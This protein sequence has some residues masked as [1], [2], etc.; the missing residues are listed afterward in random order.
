MSNRRHTVLFTMLTAALMGSS[1]MAEEKELKEVGTTRVVVAALKDD[2]VAEEAATSLVQV[3]SQTIERIGASDLASALKYES[4]IDVDMSSSGRLNDVRIRGVGGDRVMVAIDGAP[5]PQSYSFGSYLTVGRGYFDVDA[6]KSIDVIKGP[7]SMLYG[8]SALAGGIFMQTKDPADFIKAGNRYGFEAK[9]GYNT[10][11]RDRLMTLTAAAH[12]TD[13]LSGFVRATFRKHYETE[14]YNGKAFKEHHLG[15]QRVNPDPSEANVKNIL[16]KWVFEPNAEHKIAL[17]YEYFYDNSWTSLLSRK[18]SSIMG[19]TTDL[20][21]HSGTKSTRQQVNIR[22]DFNVPIALFDKGHWMAYYQNTRARQLQFEER[23]SLRKV[24]S[25]RWRKS[26]FDSD[27][28]GLTLE[29]NKGLS[30]GSV[31]H[32]LTYGANY[33]HTKVKTMRTGDTVRRIDGISIETENFPNKSFPDSKINEYGV[34]AQDRIGFFDNTVEVIAGL[35]YDHYSLKPSGD[36]AYLDANTGTMAPVGMNE[37]KLTKRLAVL[38]YPT[39]TQTLYINYAEGFKAPGFSAVNT[40]FSNL[41]H[42]YVTHSNPDLK[43]ET[44]RT[45]ELGWNFN[46]D[47]NSASLAA[48]Y[49]KYDNFIEEQVM[50]PGLQN[51]LMVFKAINLEKTHIYGLEAKTSLRMMELHNG[52]GELRF[53]GNLAYAKGKDDS[54]KEPIDSVE[55]FTAILGASYSYSDSVFVG[56]NWKLVAPKKEGKISQSLRD[57]GVTKMPGYGTLDLIAE[58]KPQ[59]NVRINAGIYNIFDKKHWSWGNRMT[60][61][62]P[63]SRE[64][65]TQPGINAG[66]FVTI[67]F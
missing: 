45:Y 38:Y 49:T 8:S 6:M 31:S 25:D 34:F 3:S 14:N 23:E 36:R 67:N 62:T 58:Y 15:S 20:G 28:A 52:D 63:I 35:R 2:R 29:F 19:V 33:K 5:L 54:T 64:R 10:V 65:G 7:V 21:T 46:D 32:E 66:I 39:D 60:Q 42:G 53:N 12:A 50:Q 55:P 61:T 30:F 22:H 13:D 57:N 41:A 44:S 43:P 9:L 27:Q 59:E 37:G 47:V 48:F 24:V 56:L 4:G 1:S 16:T 40:G 18:T 51:G 17:S 26:T 11:D